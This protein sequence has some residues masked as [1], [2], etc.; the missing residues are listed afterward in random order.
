MDYYIGKKLR[1]LRKYYN[2]SQ[3][4]LAKDI[5][6]QAYI[7]QLEKD[8]VYP[9]AQILFELANR[10]GVDLNYFFEITNTPKLDY[11]QEVYSQIDTLVQQTDYKNVLETIRLEKKNPLF[12][13][14]RHQQYLLWREGICLFHIKGDKDEA[15][16]LLNEAIALTPTTEKNYSPRELDIMSSM[17]IIYSDSGEHEKTKQIYDQILHS[18]EKIPYII[19]K[20]LFIRVFYNASKNAHNL[21]DFN[22]AV[23]LSEKGINYC[24]NEQLLY[25]LG[26]LYYQKGESLL[27]LS[28]DNK[29]IA[30]DYME[31]AL[32]IFLQKNNKLFYNYVL[33]EIEAIKAKR[34]FETT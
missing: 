15:F 14:P 16:K 5:C 20:R 23:M 31:R 21:H 24:L 18:I 32:W 12:K 11:I 17:A 30:I 27:A 7:S 34:N 25:L 9:S 28:N 33:E 29:E 22:Y 2:I 13:S 10:L 26:E 3:K 8:E 1:E 4:E 19:D 6:T